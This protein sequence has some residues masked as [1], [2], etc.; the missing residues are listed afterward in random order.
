MAASIAQLDLFSPPARQ[1]SIEREY[2]VD[3][4]P[5]TQLSDDAPV[6]FDITEQKHFLDLYNSQ[7]Y[8][9]LKLL[10]N[11][12]S[13]TTA[14]KKVVPINNTLHSIWE[15]ISVT[16]E[17]R[18]VTT[19]NKNYGYKAI[20]TTLLSYGK[21]AKETQLRAQGY[22]KDDSTKMNKVTLNT[23]SVLRHSLFEKSKS[24]ELQ[25]PLLEDIFMQKRYLL[26]NTR[27]TIRL[28]RASLP[29]T[30]INLEA[31]TNYKLKL[32]DVVFK[33]RMVELNP[34]V[35]YAIAKSLQVR[36]ALYPYTRR[37]IRV[38][39]LPVGFNSGTLDNIFPNAL[40]SRV[41]VGM[42]PSVA[43]NGNVKNN[44]FEFKNYGLTQISLSVNGTTIAT[45]TPNFD[46]PDGNGI[47]S[48]YLSLFDAFREL[49]NDFGNDILTQD[50]A[51]SYALWAFNVKPYYGVSSAN[52][53]GHARLSITLKEA[54]PEA[55]CLLIHSET[56]AMM[57]ISS[58]RNIT[59]T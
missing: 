51:R 41:I 5:V 34:T 21:T 32:E 17:G 6:I 12:G 22:Y 26:N 3:Y 44:P 29:F 10:K 19:S 7:L 52:D 57:E 39:N 8:V 27:M 1:N 47:A 15:K 54:L 28:D 11:D 37:E 53:H 38:E 59:V 31:N 58:T 23:G 35:Q 2:I 13:D 45:F 30:L 40:P 16:I 50:Y 43:Y 18:E 33:V 9:K 24:V 20:L 46:E 49:G 56:P 42:V 48:S 14:G 55:A 4:R 25:G 36:P